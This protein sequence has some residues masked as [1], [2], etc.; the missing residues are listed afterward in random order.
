MAKWMVAAKRADF[1]QI[2]EKYQITPILAR[3]LRNRDIVGDEEIHRYLHGDI[4]N[5][6]DP[7]LLKDM[8]RHRLHP[9]YTRR[10]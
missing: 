9:K 5:L 8:S 4:E 10:K 7:L 2:A 1:N 6:Y 3:I